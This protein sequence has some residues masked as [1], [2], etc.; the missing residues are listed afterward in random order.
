VITHFKRRKWKEIRI[1][2]KFSLTF[3][4]EL[5]D[6]IHCKAIGKDRK[7]MDIRGSGKWSSSELCFE[8]ERD[9]SSTIM[10]IINI[11]QLENRISTIQILIIE[12]FEIHCS[13]T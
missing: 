5:L 13:S 2:V 3:I 9:N 7:Y 6:R 8:C 12:D 10:F 11:V 4:V 1:S